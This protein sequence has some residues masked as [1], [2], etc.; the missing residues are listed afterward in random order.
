MQQAFEQRRAAAEASRKQAEQL[1]LLALTEC[2]I[3]GA[4]LSAADEKG[5]C[6]F[7]ADPILLR[8]Y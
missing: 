8:S 2:V 4:R 6:M 3:C 7:C 5:K 1:R